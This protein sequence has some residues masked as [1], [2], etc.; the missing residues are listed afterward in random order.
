M[1]TNPLKTIAVADLQTALPG[2][3]VETTP[4]AS[5]RNR[6]LLTKE[7]KR[8][9]VTLRN[10]QRAADQIA[11]LPDRH[12]SVHL[13]LKAYHFAPF[14]L[15]PAFI[16]M[17]GKPATEVLLASL[18]INS[19][20]VEALDRLIAAR[21]IKR[22]SLLL[23]HY[24][25]KVDGAEYAHAVQEIEKPG[26]QARGVR[27]HEKRI[28]ARFGRDTHLVCES[29]GNLRS[30]RSIEQCVIFNDARLFR[31]HAAWI[32]ELLESPKE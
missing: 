2:T 9:H 6:R 16:E 22:C 3:N 14:D 5:S 24:F 15:L 1:H 28:L 23:S 13:V 30:C 26:G 27:S 11:K 31:W 4:R 7:E 8:T 29:S 19:R 32:R 20:H 25:S 12:E 17:A 18:G 21:K 10:T